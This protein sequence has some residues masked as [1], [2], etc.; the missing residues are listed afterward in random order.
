MPALL[1]AKYDSA[2]VWVAADK[3]SS[4]SGRGEGGQLCGTREAQGF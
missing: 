2:V 3:V 1:G 4:R